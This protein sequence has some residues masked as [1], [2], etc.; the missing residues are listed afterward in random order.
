MPLHPRPRLP[1]ARAVVA[2]TAAPSRVRPAATPDAPVYTEEV[3]YDLSVIFDPPFEAV[4]LR[5]SWGCQ[6]GGFGYFNSRSV[7]AWA[8]RPL[9]ERRRRTTYRTPT[10]VRANLGSYSCRREPTH[11]HEPFQ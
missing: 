11:S 9:H 10:M 8:V 4:W 7:E 2:S 1:V 5:R 3:G 6:V